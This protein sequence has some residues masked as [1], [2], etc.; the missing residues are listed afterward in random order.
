MHICDRRGEGKG[1]IK[2]L[3]CRFSRFVKVVYSPVHILPSDIWWQNLSITVLALNCSEV[4]P[5][6]NSTGCSDICV[7]SV[8]VK[9]RVFV[10]KKV[11]Q[12]SGRE[13]EI[14]HETQSGRKTKK[15]YVAGLSL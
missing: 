9:T 1:S 12:A 15:I 4:L 3:E 7:C 14:C 10:E 5:T 2:E 13:Q 8:A 11:I 6:H